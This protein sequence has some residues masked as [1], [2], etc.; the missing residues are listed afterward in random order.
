MAVLVTSFQSFVLL[1]LFESSLSAPAA[2]QTG[3][4][5]C[6]IFGIPDEC[7][8]EPEHF[9][10]SDDNCQLGLKCCYTGGCGLE[11]VAPSNSTPSKTPPSTS[12]SDPCLKN[13]GGCSHDCS[14][15][16][17]KRICSC[18]EGYK[19][20]YD[21]QTC[22]DEN[23][24]FFV[25]DH[26][27][28]YRS[29]LFCED[30]P[31]GNTTCL[32]WPG[33][34]KQNGTCQ[35]YDKCKAIPGRC[36]VGVCHSTSSSYFY[37]SCPKGSYRTA[38]YSDRE[39]C[40]D[41]D[42][43]AE[44]SGGCDQVCLNTIGSFSCSC[45]PG[46]FLDI[47]GKTCREKNSCYFV[48]RQKCPSYSKSSCRD[49]PD[50]N[51]TCVC[52]RGYEKQN[53][54]CQD[55]DECKEIPG[56][57]GVGVCHNQPGS[58]YCSCPK[59]YYR[60]Y[61]FSYRETCKDDDECF[62]NPPADC[63]KGVC[64]NTPGSYICQCD[65]G[66]KFND[67]SKTC[68]DEDECAVSS[69]GCDHVCSN[70]IGSFSCG[71]H[72]GYLLDTDGKT[73]RDINPCLKNNG[74][75]SHNCSLV[76]GNRICSCPP[77]SQLKSDLRTC[78]VS[79]IG[80]AVCPIFEPPAECPEI[81]DNFCSS[82]D[83]CQYGLKCCNT[84]CELECVVPDIRPL[85]TPGT[86]D[87]PIFESPAECPAEVDNRCLTDDHCR[88]IGM[89]CC[90]TGCDLNCVYYDQC[91]EIPG[92]CGVGVCHNQPGYFYCSC[93]KGY[94]RTSRNSNEETC[95]D[96]NSCYFVG[97]QKCPS[98]SKSSCKDLPDGNTMCVCWDGYEKQNG[99]CQDV[100]ECKE[101]PD[102]C[103]VG[104]ICHNQPGYFYC[105][106]P[107]GY[108]KYAGNS[109][110]VTCEDIDECAWGS[111]GC[112]HV[113]SNTIG[114]FRCSCHPGYFLDTDGK[115]CRDENSCYFVGRQKCPYRTKSSCKDL[116]DGNTTCICWRGYKKQNGTCQDYDEC[117]AIPGRCGVGVCHNQPGSFYCSCPKGYRS[118]YIFPDGETCKDENSCYFVGRQK[119]PYRTKSSCKD[120]PDGNTTCICWRGYK[121][122]NGTCQDY[123]ECKEIPGR[124][125]VGVCHNKRGYFYCSCPKGYR[126]HWQSNGE[127][128]KDTDEC[129]SYRP[130]NCGK[131]VCVNT[132]GSY[133]CQCEP[134]YKFNDTSKTCE[135]DDECAVGSS[136][137]DHVCSNTNGS[138]SCSCH[139]GYFL[140]S[141]GKTCRA[142]KW[143]SLGRVRKTKACQEESLT[144]SCK[145][146]L[147]TLI[148]FKA[149]YA[150]DSEVCPYKPNKPLPF[151][152]IFEVKD[153]KESLSCKE[154]VTEKI[155]RWC[156]W[157]KSCDLTVNPAIGELCGPGADRYLSVVYSCGRPLKCRPLLRSDSCSGPAKDECK[158]DKECQTTQMCCFDGCKKA[159][160]EPVLYTS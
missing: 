85:G 152:Q 132:P 41:R 79:P 4:A 29:R 94:Y 16:N 63:G 67:T 128:C 119:C 130:P 84:G 34:K 77:G 64:V 140:D 116:P 139:P 22:K 104:L 108:F 147:N 13:N 148:I 83:N 141:D 114:S 10:L 39:T 109:D 11:C 19:L 3:P 124:C 154:D 37:C 57:C 43:C 48:G 113:C 151:K 133:I 135:D 87:C 71:C 55:Y 136:G 125:G 86:A 17:G 25:G 52:W 106:C 123:D 95:G 54:T 91:K 47:D 5:R 138:F 59:G 137:C 78:K 51:T 70:T 118:K 82:D 72:P 107:K 111:S 99:T 90:N 45:H 149:S 158:S 103:G 121:E 36:G 131:A 92:R 46:Y 115:T 58:F 53:G 80:K 88:P 28:P 49:L 73:C 15:V 145:D 8:A 12:D 61:M 7:P 44:G 74:G 127:T 98:D 120:L 68:K 14:F 27:C 143:E 50:G 33:Y 102:R 40:K 117:K 62:S 38:K 60:T 21:L 9:C 129:T 97:R 96:K 105:S 31:D 156:G 101:I 24:C 89:K 2:S 76:K 122:Q 66:Y 153:Y 1:C 150:G 32:C 144:M 142:V 75:C 18:P 110:T 6:P 157:K 146:S 81:P 26:K 159:C 56:R 30:L 20:F 155:N 42:E 23:S 69:S 35:Y 126:S 93:P 112:D 160:L 65:P 100:D 134:G